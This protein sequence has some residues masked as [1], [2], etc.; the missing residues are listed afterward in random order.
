MTQPIK[1][2][3]TESL[4]EYN[5]KPTLVWCESCKYTITTNLVSPKCGDC[6]RNLIVVVK[7]LITD[8]VLA[9]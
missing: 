4:I 8:D 9:R 2:P 6:R 5:I 3:Y 1:Q 7:S